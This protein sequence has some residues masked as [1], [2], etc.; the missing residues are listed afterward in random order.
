M[1][2]NKVGGLFIAFEGLDGS[3]STSQA[4][5]LKERLI[6]EGWKAFATKEPTDNLVGGLIRGVLTK[7]WQISPDGLQLLYAADRAHHLQYKILP[8]LEKNNIII[9]D[10]YA[11]S[12]IAFGALGV[13][14]EWLKNLYT[15]YIRPDVTFLIKVSARVCIERITKTRLHMELFEEE[16]KL[17]KVWKNYEK[18]ADERENKIIIID[19]EQVIERVTQ[20]VWKKMEKILAKKDY[21]NRGGI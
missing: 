8:A 11:F 20:D 21:L 18:L 19:G 14:F 16:E 15:N 13:D 4:H 1:K 9:S 12:S 3:G 7:Q 6:K 5:K 17:K 10:R 2:Q